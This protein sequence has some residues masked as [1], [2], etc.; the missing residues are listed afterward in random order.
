MVPKI[1]E[2]GTRRKAIKSCV[3]I[4]KFLIINCKIIFF[5]RVRLQMN[6]SG[7]GKS[8]YWT[9]V[10]FLHA[11]TWALLIS[12]CNFVALF[13]WRFLPES[14]RT[15]G[16]NNEKVTMSR[17]LSFFSSVLLHT[18]QCIVFSL[19]CMHSNNF[20][21]LVGRNSRSSTS[22]SA[23]WPA[24]LYSVCTQI[25]LSLPCDYEYNKKIIAS[26]PEQCNGN[27]SLV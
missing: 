9:M 15:N 3:L 1:G 5:Q 17:A 10:R 24:F 18:S 25:N 6:P 2:V 20:C 4:S 14:G 12:Y 13:D 27:A 21:F 8:K 16:I 19:H 22:S 7:T 11:T 26:L 23:I